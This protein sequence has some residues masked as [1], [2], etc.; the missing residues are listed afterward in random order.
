[1]I[2]SLARAWALVVCLGLAPLASMAQTQ[3]L[4][5]FADL[6]DKVGPSVVNIRTTE[7]ERPQDD[8]ELQEFLK[9]H[10][11][12]PD[13]GG[14]PTRPSPTPKKGDKSAPIEREVP[15]GVGSGFILTADG[16]VLTN[17]HVVEGASEIYV[18]LTDKREFKGKVIGSD[19][20]TD[21]ALVKIDAT[22]L[23]K[24]PIGDSNAIRVG[25]WVLAIGSPFGL[26]N[27]VTAGIVSAKSRET[28]DYLPFIQTDVAVNPGN[29]GGPL[30][31]MRGEVIGINSQ[32]LSENGGSLGISFAIPI[33]EAMLVVDQLRTVGKVTR[34]RLGVQIREVTKE[35]ADALGLKQQG[36]LVAHVER[37]SPAERANVQAGD[38]IQKFDGQTIEHSTDL[39]R[40]VGDTKPGTHSVV[41]VWRK[42]TVRD[43]PIVVSELDAA[44]N[45]AA[46]GKPEE[47]KSVTS[48]SLGLV[49][50]ELT[51]D[52]RKDLGLALGVVVASV[53]G[54]AAQAD[55]RPGDIIIGINNVDVN[56]TRQ[57]VEMANKLDPKKQAVLL[58]RRGDAVRYVPIKPQP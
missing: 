17:S 23:P 45:P 11:G 29:S 10:F 12:M 8:Q 19:D 54:P 16:F 36:A 26:E 32:I 43:I 39:P 20:R 28:G 15:R 57:F 56:G 52:K 50:T 44:A 30:I 53:D 22:G 35:E 21:V 7:K 18:T 13:Q 55:L 14:A 4:P 25:Q 34:G 1:M 6:V 3:V 31:N 5:D 49:V 41:T 9:K 33:D 24:L 48:N 40:I 51:E 47:P 37:G 38:I 46:P 42:G 2:R 58:V 27:T